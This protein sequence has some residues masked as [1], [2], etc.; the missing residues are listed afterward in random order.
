MTQA[1]DDSEER[2]RLA[3]NDLEFAANQVIKRRSIS[4]GNA[5]DDVDF[6]ELS[7]LT[8]YFPSRKQ[9]H[10]EDDLEFVSR[11][12][13]EMESIVASLPVPPTG[14]SGN[15]SQAEKDLIRRLNGLADECER[16]AISLRV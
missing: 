14:G 7:R 9:D 10:A 6:Q 1:F 5:R 12:R 16:R 15:A 4:W 11:V 3:A 2:A 8:H 13:K